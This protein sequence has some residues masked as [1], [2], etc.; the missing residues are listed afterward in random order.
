M[1]STVSVAAR[2]QVL[3]VE[4]NPI[5]RK[6]VRFTL[7]ANDYVVLEAKDAQTAL[8]LLAS[9]ASDLILQDI[10]LP[11]MDGF[12]LVRQLRALPGGSEIP[13]LA[14]SGFLSKQDE[15][16]IAAAGFNDVVM[17]PIEPS[18]L[19]H[20]IRAHLPAREAVTGRF[21]EGR[22][23]L[24]VD[25]DPVQRKLVCIRLGHLG[26]E[27]TAVSDGIEALEMARRQPHDAIV[28]DVM[29]PRL[30]GFGLCMAV[31]SDAALASTPLIL[32][33]NSY[34]EEADRE[35]A[36]RAGA[37]EFVLRT[38]DMPELIAALRG[39]LRS[40]VES[41]IPAE[42]AVPQLQ[43]QWA[44][45]VMRQLERQV[46]LNAGF[47]QRCATLSAELS[48]LSGISDALAR[49]Q[50]IEVALTDV[51][52]ACFD[53]G[54]ASL[55]ALYVAS[56]TGR[57]R[58]HRFGARGHWTDDEINTFF[59]RLALLRSLI[60]STETY[61][62]PSGHTNADADGLLA[63]ARVH[64]ALVVPLRR[65]D[66]P[67]GALLMA[68]TTSDLN[69]PDRVTFVQGVAMQITQALA[70]TQAFAEKEASETRSREHAAILRSVLESIA[71]G[72]VV[73]NDLGE[74]LV[75]NSAAQG[76][77]RRD[78]IDAPP[79]QWARLYGISVPGDRAAAGPQDLP[80]VRAMRGESVDQTELFVRHDATSEGAYLRMSARPLRDDKGAVRGGVAVFRDVTA[81]RATQAQLM[82]ADRM[83]S[84][85]TLAAGVAHEIN[86]PLACV[87]GN[88]HLVLEQLVEAGVD[89]A[90]GLD[91]RAIVAMLRDA[92]DGA[93][94]VS[95]IVKDLRLFARAETET[96]DVVDVHAV[97]ESTLRMAS[98]E[99]RH[100]A[101][102]EKVYGSI[103][104]VV[105]NE[106]RLGQIFLNLVVNA[107]QAIPEG[108]ADKN[109]IRVSTF[110]DAA[111][112]VAV[113]VADTGVGITPEHM[114]QM[115]TPF[116]TTKPVGV[117][118]GLGLSIC[119]RLLSAVGGTISV[120][121]K[122]DVGTTFRVTLQPSQANEAS[123]KPS[124]RPPILVP[125]RRARVLIV[126][127]EPMI[128]TMVQKII[129]TDHDLIGMTRASEARDRI[130]RGERFDLILCDLM[131]PVMTGM[132]LHAAI[133]GI[134]P[135]QAEA[136]VF[137]TGGAFTPAARAFIDT[138]PNRRLQKP[139]DARTLRSLVNLSVS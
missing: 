47:A 119:H 18:R 98:T 51:L 122:L 66:E 120:E 24:V 89:S 104:L 99:I 112:R 130:M 26:F 52:S 10:V 62:L 27:T 53:A 108:Q 133:Q 105:A 23:L 74:C 87:L 71:E 129:G 118:T 84:I 90:N 46:A 125:A 111:G 70:L 8:A 139:F 15:S 76:I 102:V 29:M 107:A 88:V 124:Q 59:G 22:R 106:A 113:E 49:H 33:T 127:D 132:E 58:V 12:E 68:S 85:G 34:I 78:A 63:A 17:K 110:V 77:L 79:E 80:L 117:G 20:V 57:L 36:L 56:A 45:R 19:L 31:R 73:T 137:I 115:F 1:T 2:A 61:A 48:V 93:T 37:N 75:W 91:L 94:R 32:V 54:G 126:D 97:L 28:A 40:G 13:I 41:L 55:G 121:S 44:R 101:R 4:D 50:N 103:P 9:H 16:R 135:A 42:A 83:A 86:N 35:L 136:M 81:E 128:V 21:G 72:V 25:D 114:K 64:S 82:V 3:V 14:F 43:E 109:E 138:M 60:G 96:P 65:R 134:D 11:D 38:P 69:Q 30:D 92:H 67:F 95:Q 123:H 116:F 100:R 5:T 7:E 6:L 131:M 39:C